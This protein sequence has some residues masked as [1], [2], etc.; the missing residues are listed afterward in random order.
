VSPASGRG[1]VYIY[2][3]SALPLLDMGHP[4]HVNDV[5]VEHWPRPRT[6]L[7]I[8][9]PEGEVRV[10]IHSGEIAFSLK[11]GDT[12]Y[13]KVG[14]SYRLG[15]TSLYLELVHPDQAR[16]EIEGL[17]L[18]GEETGQEDPFR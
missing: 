15:G 7:V 8:D 18:I 1:R 4:V 3:P 14:A 11:S 16:P 13:V 10:R 6:F 12:R 5:L 2:R 17:R 9:Q